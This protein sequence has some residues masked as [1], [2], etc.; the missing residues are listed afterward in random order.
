MTIRTTQLVDILRE[1]E[2]LSDTA[3]DEA[4]RLARS[5]G[6]PLACHLL[7]GGLMEEEDLFFLLSRRGVASSI[8]HDHVVQAEPDT[9]LKD[10]VP[11]AV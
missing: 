6:V 1:E 11:A 5:A 9:E 3:L 7:D 4:V 10:R 8:P 2:V